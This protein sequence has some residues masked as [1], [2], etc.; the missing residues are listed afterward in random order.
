[1]PFRSHYTMAPADAPLPEGLTPIQPTTHAA[2]PLAFSS[3]QAGFPSPAEGYAE[4]AI[5]FNEMLEGTH[6]AT[7]AIRA[8]GESMTEAGISDGD[9]LV[10]DRSRRPR[11]GDIVV[12]QI[13]NEFTVKRFME[14]PDGTPYLHPE[15]RLPDFK[16][17]VPSEFEE[18]ICFGVVRHIIKSL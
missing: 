8:R 7:F 6:P 2:V 3:V 1:M 12:M 11:A 14:K 10:V 4:K 15:S 17:I 5:D 18:W 13:N 9:L 16:D